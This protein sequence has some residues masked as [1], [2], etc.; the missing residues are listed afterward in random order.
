V[1]PLELLNVT[2]AEWSILIASARVI[3]QDREEQDRKAKR[4]K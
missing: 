2:D 4:G 3:A 1:N